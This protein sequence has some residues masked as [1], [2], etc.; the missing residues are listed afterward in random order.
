MM[1]ILLMLFLT[2]L[3]A[4]SCTHDSRSGSKI[5]Y[6]ESDELISRINIQLMQELTK[7]RT[8]SGF[9]G[10]S[11]SYFL[12]DGRSSH[13][14]I[15]F[16]DVEGSVPMET[17]RMLGASTGK[18]I[19]ATCALKLVEQGKIK[20][21]DPV[22]K[23]FANDEWFSRLPNSQALTLRS[24]LNHTSGLPNHNEMPEF[25][26]A[27]RALTPDTYFEPIDLIKFALDRSSGAVVGE[28]F[29]YSDTNYI[30]V[31]LIIE[32]ITNRKYYDIA[33]ELLSKAE[34]LDTIPSNTRRIENLAA[35]YT[36]R[37]TSGIYNIPQKVT[38]DGVLTY[39]PG[40]EWTG[41]GFATT[42]HDLAKWVFNFNQGKILS[43]KLIDEAKIG[44]PYTSEQNGLVP[45]VERY[46]LGIMIF[47]D[48]GLGAAI[49]HPGYALGYRTWALYFPS[50]SFSIALMVN[51]DDKDNLKP[52]FKNFLKAAEKII[53]ESVSR[54]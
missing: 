13:V 29:A 10:V 52:G 32:R 44:V 27:F 23:W 34:L 9:P 12:P 54:K 18:M 43:Q 20:L 16:A 25:L 17:H 28:K 3:L 22:A 41:G 40:T 5:A 1:K 47:R 19:A 53:A 15:G 45:D 50:A 37:D 38:Q 49:G 7:W 31:G 42:S 35:G 4:E 51:T 30:L 24:L 2:V 14:S 21:D 39:H 26:A 48:N 36:S 8:K 46:G 33:S 6:V 11:L